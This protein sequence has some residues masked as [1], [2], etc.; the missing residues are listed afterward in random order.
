M[1]VTNTAEPSAELSH[2]A[3]LLRGKRIALLTGAGIS[4]DSGIPAYRGEGA[5]TRSD[6][7]TIQTYLGDEA[8]RRRVVLDQVA[9]LTDSTALEWHHTLVQGAEFTRVWI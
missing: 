8:A 7:M 1:S 2:A 6:P 3:D 5:R 9:S 4:T